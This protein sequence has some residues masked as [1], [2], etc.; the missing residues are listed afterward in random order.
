MKIGERAVLDPHCLADFK[1]NLGSR[2]FHAL[3]DLMQDVLYF[4]LADGRGLCGRPADESSHLRGVLDEV[5]SFVG[6]LHLDQHIAGE[7]LPFAD[8]LLSAAHFHDLLDR[9]ENLAELI[10]HAGAPDAVLQ[11]TLHALLETGISVHHKPFFAHASPW[12]MSFFTAHNRLAS[13]SHRNR[14]MITTN[15]NT[16]PVVCKVSLRVGH[17]TFL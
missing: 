11:R 12:P 4:L 16:I 8:V 3:L 5:P 2:L 13:T 14:A 17:T 6:H 7:E 1:Q 10:L 15:T 9:H